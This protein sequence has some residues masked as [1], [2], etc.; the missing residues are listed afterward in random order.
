MKMTIT[1]DKLPYFA[2]KMSTLA[3]AMDKYGR[4]KQIDML[5]EECGEL[6]VSL[7]HLKRGRVTWTDVASEMAD[8]SIMIEQMNTIDCVDEAYDRFVDEKL[9]RL[10]TRLKEAD[11]NDN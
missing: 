7:Q 6:I 9:K 3:W 4:E 11:K 2:W 10:E 5:I 8:V 1:K